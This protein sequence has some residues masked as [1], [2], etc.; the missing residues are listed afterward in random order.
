MTRSKRVHGEKPL[1]W[2]EPS[3]DDLL[4]F[5]E[6]VIDEIGTALSVAQ[7]GGKHPSA[8][9]WRGEGPGVFEG[10]EDH[11]AETFR[12][13]Y[14]VKFA[15]AIYVLH[16]F[17]KKSPSGIMTARKDIELIGRRLDESKAD[18]KARYAKDKK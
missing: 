7:F 5:P 9:P 6:A 14:T 10:V 3:K 15:N 12:L 1:F 11:R 16:A 4:D 18:Y 2:T 8:K 17:Q 13:V